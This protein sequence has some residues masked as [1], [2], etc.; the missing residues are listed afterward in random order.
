MLEP[1]PDLSVETPLDVAPSR[2]GSKQAA[3]APV[4]GLSGGLDDE[5]AR[6]LA[7]MDPDL[8]LAPSQ[9]AAR[10]APSAAAVVI[11]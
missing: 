1:L 11:P 5:E 10:P 8:Q 9:A 2:P 6:A 7:F 4:A 3:A